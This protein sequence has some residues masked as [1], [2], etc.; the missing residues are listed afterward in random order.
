MY[1]GWYSSCVR[2]FSHRRTSSATW[3]G[4]NS[5]PGS[6]CRN[7]R[8]SFATSIF[9]QSEVELERKKRN[10]CS[11]TEA[12]II[13]LIFNTV[14]NRNALDFGTKWGSERFYQKTQ[15]IGLTLQ[16][17]GFSLSMMSVILSQN[18][19]WNLYSEPSIPTVTS[20]R[21]IRRSRHAIPTTGEKT[22][23]NDNWNERQ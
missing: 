16:F 15:L 11:Q 4:W 20:F 3:S 10:Y 1:I 2:F 7:S 8:S 13:T 22:N 12:P 19:G 14:F 5:S 9:R 23:Q 6:S 18:R 21:F 17:S